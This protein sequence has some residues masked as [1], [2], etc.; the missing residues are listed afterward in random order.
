MLNR[1]PD[2]AIFSHTV[3]VMQYMFPRQFGLHN[4]FTS[5]VDP[6]E[7]V[8]PFKDY[9]LREKE[10]L[11]SKDIRSRKA[12]AAENQNS[13]KLPKRLRGE[14]PL[15]VSKLQKRHKRCA[16]VELLKHYC[17]IETIKV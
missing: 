7:T 16:Y 2:P 14:L 15:L 1:Y 5:R 11:L 12:A 3:R 10:I 17:P 4:V 9:T 13:A 6:R 8:Q